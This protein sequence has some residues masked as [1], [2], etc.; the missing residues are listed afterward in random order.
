MDKIMESGKSLGRIK[1]SFLPHFTNK[2]TSVAS[3]NHI[4]NNLIT[5]LNV[6]TSQKIFQTMRSYVCVNISATEVVLFK[7]LGEN[8]VHGQRQQNSNHILRQVPQGRHFIKLRTQYTDMGVTDIQYTDMGTW[9]TW[10]T[11]GF[12]F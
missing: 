2:T 9:G 5:S 8:E 6:V 12:Q 3:R 4:C 10:G 1:T 11:W 7:K